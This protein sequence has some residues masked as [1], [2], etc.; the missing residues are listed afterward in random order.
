MKQTMSEI[1]IETRK[2][3][4]YNVYQIE[5]LSKILSKWNRQCLK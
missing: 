2:Q 4:D 5:T 3:D 1:I